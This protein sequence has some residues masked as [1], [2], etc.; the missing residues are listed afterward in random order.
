MIIIDIWGGYHSQDHVARFVRNMKD[1]LT[2]TKIELENGFLV[3]LRLEKNW[4]DFK[5]FDERMN[6]ALAS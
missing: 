2:I 4:Q 5:E 3:N 6:N 1:A